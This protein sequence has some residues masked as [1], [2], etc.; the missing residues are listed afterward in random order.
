[1]LLPGRLFF[2]EGKFFSAANALFHLLPC[3]P[4]PVNIIIIIKP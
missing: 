4:L 3:L 1:M 2:Q